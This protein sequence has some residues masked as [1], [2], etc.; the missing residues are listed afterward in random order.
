MPEHADVFFDHIEQGAKRAG[1]SLLDLDLQVG[2]SVHFTDEVDEAV[3]SLRP[4]LAFSLGAM[5][6]KQF[7][8]YNAAYRRAGY[9]EEAE[10]VQRLW[11]DGDRDEAR[12]LV[13]AEMILK[14]NLIGTDQMVIW[15]PRRSTRPSKERAGIPPRTGV[16]R[17]MDEC[18]PT[19]PIWLKI[20]L[21]NSSTL[22]Q[23]LPIYETL[24]VSKTIIT[25]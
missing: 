23:P 19:F 11:L 1:R 16:R 12:R 8:F 3:E 24:A 25:P 2:G 13:P 6:S 7:N 14:S 22:F 20:S 21:S 4:S 15:R 18:K 5:G 17:L 9:A 10:E